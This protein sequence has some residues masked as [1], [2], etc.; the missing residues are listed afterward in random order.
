MCILIFH[1]DSFKA[2]DQE[3]IDQKRLWRAVLKD[4]DENQPIYFMPEKIDWILLS[5]YRK[6][7]KAYGDSKK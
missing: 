3:P 6:I 7:R 5:E 1:L 2:T 4:T